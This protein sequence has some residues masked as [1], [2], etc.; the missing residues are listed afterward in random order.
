MSSNYGQGRGPG[1]PAG[2]GSVRTEARW[3]ASHTFPGVSGMSACVTPN[4]A[5][6]STTELTTAGGEPTVADSPMPLAPTGWCGDGVTVAPSS[7]EG[8]SSDV[9][10]R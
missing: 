7:G 6:A 8:H 10:S 3:T 4:G 1:P 9:G 2:D 5:S